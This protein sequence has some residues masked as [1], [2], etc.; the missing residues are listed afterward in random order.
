MSQTGVRV[1]TKEEIRKNRIIFFSAV[2]LFIGLVVLACVLIFGNGRTDQYTQQGPKPATDSTTYITGRDIYDFYSAV[3]FCDEVDIS[4]F[5]DALF[6]GESHVGGLVLVNDTVGGAAVLYGNSA[7]VMGGLDASFV[8]NLESAAVTL[9]SELEKSGYNKI[10]IQ[11]GLNEL[12]WQQK[13][14]FYETYKAMIE[15]IIALEPDADI[16]IM[17]LFPVSE[18]QSA[19]SDIYNNENIALYNGYIKQIASELELFYLDV[20]S[21][22]ANEDGTLNSGCTDNGI[23]IS[24]ASYYKWYDYLVTHVAPS[25]VS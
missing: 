1:Y 19:S 4:F 13:V 2:A 9:K 18:R 22:Y 15:A 3:P 23:N 20:A 16:Y 14:R 7:S 10:Y 11:F 12:G 8:S 25:Y 21:V 24:Y 5:D 6:V 17:N